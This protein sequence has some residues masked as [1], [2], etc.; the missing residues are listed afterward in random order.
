MLDELAGSGQSD[1][2]IITP[3]KS[4]IKQHDEGTRLF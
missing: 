2:L 1:N 3:G 4:W